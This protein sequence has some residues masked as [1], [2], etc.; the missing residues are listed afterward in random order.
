MTFFMA[1]ARLAPVQCVTWGHPV[2]SGIPNIDYFISSTLLE[3]PGAESQY[4]ERLVTLENL[5]TYYYPPKRPQQ[6]GA[7]RT[8]PCPLTPI[9]PFARKVCS[10]CIRNSTPCCRES[11]AAV[12]RGVC[13]C[14]PASSRTGPRSSGSDLSGRFPTWSTASTS[15]RQPI[16]WPFLECWPWSTWFS[17]AA[18]QRRQHQLRGLCR[19][20]ADRHHARSLYAVACHR[21]HVS[22]YGNFRLRG[23]HPRGVRADCRA[24]GDRSGLASEICGK[25]REASPVLF[26]NMAFIRE[27][28]DTLEKM[29]RQPAMLGSP[30]TIAD[31]PAMQAEA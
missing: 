6:R 26:E 21:G 15:A 11:S 12:R 19:R 8:S 24:A 29:V 17:T 3:L 16:D 20:A 5:P 28:E 9:S 1:F 30:T 4:T 23:Q 13:S 27:L 7:A 10:R 14:W 18:L 2:T 22:P 31:T 25:I